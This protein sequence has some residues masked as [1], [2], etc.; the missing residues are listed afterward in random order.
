[1]IRVWSL[2]RLPGIELREGD[3]RHEIGA[4]HGLGIEA[5]DGS[6]LLARFQLHEGGHDAGGADVHGDPEPEGCRIAGLHGKNA[7]APRGDGD[8]AAV[9]AKR[10]G[11][12]ADDLG[13]HVLDAAPG[14]PQQLLQV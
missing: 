4:E 11:Q 9:L 10:L 13:G 12:P 3:P 14:R 1:M 6:E 5:R 7:P 2:R 8:L